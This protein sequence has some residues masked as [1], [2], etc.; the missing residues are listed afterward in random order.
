MIIVFR[1]EPP[2][3]EHALQALEVEDLE[4]ANR[5][6]EVVAEEAWKQ[7]QASLSERGWVLLRPKMRLLLNK[8]RDSGISFGTLVG[9]AIDRGITTGYNR[10]FVIDEVVRDRL[11]KEDPKSAEIIKPWL[12]G[13]DI[14]RWRVEWHG[15]YI[16]FTR[17]GIDIE[18]YPAVKAYLEQFKER[19][20]PGTEKGRK[21]GNYEW[22]EIQDTTAY[23][24][25]FKKPK[26]VWPDIAPNPSFAYDTSG[27]FGGNTMYILPAKD[28]YLLGILNSRV[29]EFF[30]HQI[31]S[32]I[33]G[34][35]LRFIATYMK[36]IPIPEPTPAQREAIEALVGK[37]LAAEGQGP[38]VPAWERALNE[39]V[40][41]VY[42]LTAEEI[43]LVEPPNEFGG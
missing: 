2:D 30:Y 38:R 12:N 36:Q 29:V 7:P 6:P 35:Y 37:L 9:D 10:A 25:Q 17:R 11:L 21:A 4:V 41:E 22:Y 19:L 18:S 8:L 13:R 23:Y 32:T 15:K 42:E 16:I 3:E 24:A 33:R 27:V 20:M 14:K 39:L 28:V 31:S 43:A 1:K 34:D 40:Y 5:L 26:I